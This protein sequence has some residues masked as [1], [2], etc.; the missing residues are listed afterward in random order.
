[1][2]KLCNV[3]DLDGL[4]WEEKELEVKG[5]QKRYCDRCLDKLACTLSRHAGDRVQV[6]W[7]K[8]G[9]TVDLIVAVR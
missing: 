4:V 7:V 9:S 1:M 5:L 2:T 6:P 8:K 3:K